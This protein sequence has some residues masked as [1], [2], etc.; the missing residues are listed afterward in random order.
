[1]GMVLH[2]LYPAEHLSYILQ[3]FA[4]QKLKSP[5]GSVLPRIGEGAHW[6]TEMGRAQ[7]APP[8]PNSGSN[9]RESQ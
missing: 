9:S 1:M 6:V 7:H 4:K 3:M 2:P 5:N 8:F